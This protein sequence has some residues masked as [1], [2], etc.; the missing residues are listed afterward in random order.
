MQYKFD[1]LRPVILCLHSPLP[2]PLP[3]NPPHTHTHTQRPPVPQG[4]GRGGRQRGVGGRGQWQAQN[5]MDEMNGLGIDC[6]TSAGSDRPTPCAHPSQ[7]RLQAH[8]TGGKKKKTTQKPLVNLQQLFAAHFRYIKR[9]YVFT[10]SR[11]FLFAVHHYGAQHLHI[12]HFCPLSSCKSVHKVL[13][14][15]FCL[16]LSTTEV[17]IYIHCTSAA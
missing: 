2:P 3:L 15:G 12:M 4:W 7:V 5:V 13:A 1:S 8:S 17:N 11:S 14:G 10:K 9:L 16:Q 6:A